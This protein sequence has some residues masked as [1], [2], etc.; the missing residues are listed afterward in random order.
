M[1]LLRRVV[2][3]PAPHRIAFALAVQWAAEQPGREVRPPPQTG[4]AREM[5]SYATRLWHEQVAS[6]L[7][8]SPMTRIAASSIPGAGAGCFASEQLR[9]GQ[10]VTLYPGAV[11]AP[12]GYFEDPA[13]LPQPECFGDSMSLSD[14]AVVEG[15]GGSLLPRPPR[16]SEY[17]LVRHGGFKIDASP[18]APQAALEAT[19]ALRTPHACGHKL[20]HPPSGSTPNTLEVPVVYRITMPSGSYG[21]NSS[22]IGESNRIRS[23][24]GKDN[25]SSSAPA[26]AG[27]SSSAAAVEVPFELRHL[28]PHW[29]PPAEGFVAS[30]L[31]PQLVEDVTW[32]ARVH[33]CMRDGRL[34]MSTATGTPASSASA[35]DAAGSSSS[36]YASTA[37]RL[38]PNA[39]RNGVP[40]AALPSH[41]DVP[42]FAMVATRAIAAGEELFLDYGFVDD[43]EGLPGWYR[44]VSDEHVKEAVLAAEAAADEARKAWR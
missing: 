37:P 44:E 39:R 27:L 18:I 42:G 31:P 14:G 7:A 21:H 5:L 33:S 6:A 43:G 9:A 40:L 35:G 22:G 1:N 8:R 34:A 13:D 41:I 15:T 36:A 2:T 38:V 25:T 12:L 32:Q 20:Q 16:D 23:G 3:L 26:A 24:Y 19:W 4:K 17:V 30:P 11:Y 10:L 28:V 29:W